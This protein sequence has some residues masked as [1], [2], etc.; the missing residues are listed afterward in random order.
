MNA[1]NR[2]LCCFLFVYFYFVS[3]VLPVR[4]FVHLKFVC[5]EKKINRF[6]IVLLASVTYGTN[7]YPPQ[8]IYR[9]LYLDAF[10]F[11]CDFLRASLFLWKSFCLRESFFPW[12]LFWIFF[13][14]DNI[15]FFMKTFLNLF[16]LWESLF[17]ENSFWIFFICE[18][19]LHFLICE[20]SFL[21][22]YKNKP[23][24]ECHHLKQIFCYRKQIK[25]FS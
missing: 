19:F 20:N 12:K 25:T 21:S 15:F 8:S 7:V 13:V 18:N 14:C 2:C 16:Y 22:L 10:I 3:W 17:N 1:K 11:I 6:K 5:K 4:V 23:A 24:N 9:G